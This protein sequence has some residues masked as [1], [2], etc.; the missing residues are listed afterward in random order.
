MYTY[1]SSSVVTLK[2]ALA[3]GFLCGM[4][5]K[6]SRG[7]QVEGMK[8]SLGFTPPPGYTGVN[9][10][11][12]P[13]YRWRELHERLEQPFKKQLSILCE[14]GKYNSTDEFDR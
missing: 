11:F 14:M 7:G 13:C 10:C 3:G 6:N 8:N 1:I 2:P 12:F 9:A 4:D 5:L